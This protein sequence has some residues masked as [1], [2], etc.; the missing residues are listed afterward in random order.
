M[1]VSQK[2]F[3]AL[4]AMIALAHHYQQGAVRIRDIA[5]EER[6]PQKFLDIILIE[7]KNARLVDST[8]GARG[9][10]QLRRPPSEIHLS[11]VIRLIDGPLAPFGDADQLRSLMDTDPNCRALYKVFL[12]VRN[13]AA[14]VLDNTSIADVACL[15][16]AA[17]AK[18][19]LRT[20]PSPETA[21]VADDLPRAK[22]ARG[23][24]LTL[25]G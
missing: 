4:K 11:E 16:A 13:A 17:D 20:T 7:L 8:R 6:L 15:D 21:S 10:Y 18:K 19:R 22:Q 2:G 3:Y 25:S 14:K 23:R 9:G 1:K 24:A 5:E 12:D